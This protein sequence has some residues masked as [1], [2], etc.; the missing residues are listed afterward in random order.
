M[1]RWQSGSRHG[2][3]RRTSHFRRNRS[4]RAAGSY[5][6]S[7]PAPGGGGPAS[8]ERLCRAGRVRRRSNHQPRPAWNGEMTQALLRVRAAGQVATGAAGAWG[9]ETSSPCVMCDAAGAAPAAAPARRRGDVVV[10]R[11]GLKPIS[12]KMGVGLGADFIYATSRMETISYM[13]LRQRPF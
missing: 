13:G 10:S 3:T 2:N 4:I 11:G 9:L 12:P 7:V 6:V 1:D 8:G 5:S